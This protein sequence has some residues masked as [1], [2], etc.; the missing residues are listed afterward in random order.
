MKIKNIAGYLQ[1]IL[2]VKADETLGFRLITWLSKR[3]IPRYRFT[4]P[5]LAWFQDPAIARVLARFDESDGYNAHRKYA[6]QQLL[7]LTYMVPGDT[8]ECGVYKGCSSYI[9]LSANKGS[10]F[11]RVHHIFDSFEGL[12]KPSGADGEY[13]SESDLSI[14]EDVVKSNLSEF[15][16]VKFYKGW[17]P[18]RFGEVRDLMFSFVHVDVDLYA[19]TLDSAIFFYDRL[20]DGG[21][22]LC[23]DY[24]FLTCPGVTLAINEF[25]QDKPEKMIA[26]PGGGGFFIKG[27][28]AAAE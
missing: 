1:L 13:W 20:T 26:L 16:R 9:M 21:I 7:R 27:C 14:S 17:I 12:S 10:S 2:G 23:D 22:F 8:A 6:L 19:P 5:E 4:W 28:A 25:L 18:E 15:E 11:N 3:F 24:G